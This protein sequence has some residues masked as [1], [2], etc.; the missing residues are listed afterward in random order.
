MPALELES[1]WG[2]D[3]VLLSLEV[4]EKWPATARVRI[5]RVGVWESQEREHRKAEA[6]ERKASTRRCVMP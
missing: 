5:A 4:P 2:C 6:F 1:Q 3:A